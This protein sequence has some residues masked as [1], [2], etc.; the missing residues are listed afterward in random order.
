MARVMRIVVV[1]AVCLAVLPAARADSTGNF[2]VLLGGRVFDDSTS[3]TPVD[4][5]VAIGASFDFAVPS[6]AVNWE[7]AINASSKDR[8]VA[9]VNG[10]AVNRELELLEL[11]T[12]IVKY[13]G[14]KSR[15]Y[16]GAGF[17]AVNVDTQG[18][19]GPAS[20]A[21]DTTVGAYIRGGA[22]FRVGNLFQVG[23]DLRAMVGEAELGASDTSISYYQ[24]GLLLG[25]GW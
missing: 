7:F 6:W 20:A 3:W 14:R 18:F 4:E 19:D 13:W 24:A 17:S 25:W 8:D 9:D 1:L 16:I 12:G 21:G 11:S 10:F 22:L 15:I 5:Q 2:S 23:V